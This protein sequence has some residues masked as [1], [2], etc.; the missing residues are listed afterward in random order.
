MDGQDL[1]D[2]LIELDGTPT[3]VPGSTGSCSTGSFD[4]LMVR[5]AHHERC[6]WR[7]L[8]K[9][10]GLAEGYEV[11][12]AEGFVGDVGLED[13]FKLTT[14][15]VFPALMDG[16]GRGCVRSGAAQCHGGLMW[17]VRIDGLR[18]DSGTRRLQPG[19]GRGFPCWMATPWVRQGR[20]ASPPATAQN[21]GGFLLLDGGVG[22][23]MVA[24]GVVRP[25]RSTANSVFCLRRKI[26][27]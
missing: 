14:G 19:G 3:H 27:S 11:G 4:R 21:E 24:S 10:V 26:S 22:F 9:G 20:I 8:R 15:V 17:V 25:C 6:G 13:E 7:L 1:Q 5:R 23:L 12:A 2:D 18:P 16:E